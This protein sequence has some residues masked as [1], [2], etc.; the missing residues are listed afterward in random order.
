[1]SGKIWQ[2]ISIG[3]ALSLNEL[4]SGASGEEAAM[5][6]LLSIVLFSALPSGV[7]AQEDAANDPAPQGMTKPPAPAV[8]AHSEALDR[9]QALPK[10]AAQKDLNTFD[11]A[12][13]HRERAA[14]MEEKTNGLWQSWLVSV[15]EGCGPDGRRFTDQSGE[16]YVRRLRA[17]QDRN[18]ADRPRYTYSYP[19]GGDRSARIDNVASH[20]TNENIDQIRRDPNR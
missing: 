13:A 3:N 17:Q 9:L 8:T 5:R 7:L 15:C 18:A 14:S 19:S 11:L 4:S 16:A 2:K 10:P 12:S 6:R 1:V 20:L